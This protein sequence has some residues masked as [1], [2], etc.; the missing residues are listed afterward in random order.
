VNILFLKYNFFSKKP[1]FILAEF[2]RTQIPS[3][4]FHRY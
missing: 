4:G 3:S 1:Y 2:A